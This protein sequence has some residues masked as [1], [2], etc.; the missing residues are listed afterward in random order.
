MHMT[1]S[2]LVWRI[3]AVAPLLAA[4][5]ASAPSSDPPSYR[6][7]TMGTAPVP[8]VMPSPTGSGPAPTPP[9]G[10][11]Q[12]RD[13]TPYPRIGH[14]CV[15]DTMG[16]RLVIAG[17][18]GNDAWAVPLSGPGVGTW[19]Q[20]AVAG[21]HPPVH[22]YGSSMF[23]DAA[24]FDP[25]TRRMF[26][27]QNRWPST[28][29]PV[30]DVTL[31]QLSLDGAATWSE[32]VAAGPSPGS[33]IQSGR[34]VVDAIG[35]RLIAFGGAP[36]RSGV[37]SLSL[38]G[39]P[40]WS[41]LADAPESGF[42]TDGSMVLDEVSHRLIVFGGHPRLRKLWALSLETSTWALLDKG[43]NASGSYGVT[44]TFDPER[45]AI[46]LVG[47]D[48]HD[49]VSSYSLET[50]SWSHA[51][52]PVPESGCSVFDGARG[53]ALVFGG[54]DPKNEPTNATVAI[55]YATLAPSAL[56]PRTRRG[57]PTFGDRQVV[58]DPTRKAIVAF[59]E[60]CPAATTVVRGLDP[61]SD[62]QTIDVGSTPSV[63]FAA[64]IYDTAGQSIVL[65]GGY[66]YGDSKGLWRLPSAPGATWQPIGALGPVERSHHMAVFDETRGRMIVYGG[67]TQS[68]TTKS[69]TIADVWALALAPDPWWTELTPANVG[70]GPREGAAAVYDSEHDR[71]IV[72]GGGTFDGAAYSDVW[73]LSLADPPTWTQ[74][75]PS[76]SSLAGA[77]ALSAVYDPATRRA[78]VVDP[79]ADGVRVHALEL[80][81][82]PR[83]RDFCPGP[84]SLTP[85]ST[86]QFPGTT[87]NAVLAPDGLF[88]AVSGGGFRF[89]PATPYCEP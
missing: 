57:D 33:E 7:P 15:L 64:A 81:D 84:A 40:K 55:E 88:L 48:Q 51:S 34:I 36:S 45:R 35:R 80:G 17:G 2:S 83:L 87:G 77:T 79:R 24:A 69:T 74:L 63:S 31:L 26:V 53:R 16:D 9:G 52:V 65:F 85:G 60:E 28:G 38:D 70:P 32:V 62:F 25:V 30:E 61:A 22:P 27:M 23:A 8:T 44:T 71:M 82:N 29:S 89:D 86:Y 68:G 78:L 50:G 58:F 12:L 76:M 14:S 49:G 19:S 39:A 11:W 73:A 4:C 46:V 43:N 67:A 18:G 75:V 20:L 72:I 42:F 3:A 37:W 13:A 10:G 54:V 21:P 66:R 56:F 41:R 59:G 1:S 5:S 47:G 6:A